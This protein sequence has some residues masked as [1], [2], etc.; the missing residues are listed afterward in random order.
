MIHTTSQAHSGLR[1]F[2]FSSILEGE[3]YDQYLRTPELNYT[4]PMELSFWYKRHTF[5]TETFRV[6][7]STNGSSWTWTNNITDADTFWKK[8][9]MTL[10]AGTKYVEIHYRS[11]YRWYLFID[12][13]SIHEPGTC[14]APIGLTANSITANSAALG[15]T[16]T[17]QASTWNIE[18]GPE[19]F[20]QGNGTLLQTA[21][22]PRTIT[23][24]LPGT[25]YSFYVQAVCQGNNSSWAGPLSF[26]TLCS[27]VSVFSE[28]FDAVISPSL[29]ICWG[30]AGTTGTVYTQ[31]VNAFSPPNCLYLYSGS[32]SNQ[33]VIAMPEVVNI[34]EGTHRLRFMARANISSGAIIEAGYLTNPSDPLS[35][36]MLQA[37]TLSLNYEEYIV[38]PGILGSGDKRLAFRASHSPAYSL[39]VDNVIWEE[40]SETPVFSV[41]PSIWNFG[42]INIGSQ[43]APKTFT[44]TNTGSGVLW[45]A[46]PALENPE[47][48]SLDYNAAHFPASLTANA[49]VTFDVIFSP[50]HSGPYNAR[51][52]VDF[53]NG[54]EGFAT[55]NLSGTGVERPEGS[56]CS[57]PIVI[58]Q[59]PLVNFQGNTELMGNDYSHKW[60]DPP[61]YFINGND[62]VFRFSLNEPGYLSGTMTSSESW[63]GL[64]IL[65]QCPNQ[66]QPAQVLVS[67]T[68]NGSSVSFFDLLLA[69]GEY[70]AIVSSYPPPQT[71]TFNLNLLIDPLPA[72]PQPTGLTATSITTT[73]AV[74]GWTANGN[75]NSWNVEY[76]LDGFEPGSGILLANVSNPYIL[77][78]LEPATAYAF[79]VQ[80]TGPGKLSNWA[81]PH[82]FSTL[83]NHFDIPFFENFDGVSTPEIP[84]C[85]SVINQNED[86]NQWQTVSFNASS[87]PNAMSINYNSAMDMDDWFFTPGLNLNAGVTYQ[88]KF[89][90]RAQASYY[91]EK[92]RVMWGLAPY[93]EEM[94]MGTIWDNPGISNTSYQE[95][96]GLFT[97]SVSGVYYLG[98][99]GYS[100]ADMWRLFVDDISVEVATA[101]FSL[102]LSVIIEGAFAP[103]NEVLMHTGINHLL[104]LSQPYGPELPYFGNNSPVWYYEGKESVAAMPSNVVDWVLIELRD[105]PEAE[106]A[107]IPLARKAALLL[108]T[109]QVVATNG[110]PL[111]FQQQI[112]QGLFVVIYHRN[113]LAIMSSEALTENNG[114]YTWDF[115]SSEARAFYNNERSPL[116]QGLKNL[117]NDAYAMFGGDADGNGQ[118]Q[119][120]DK[121]EVWNP[122]SGLSG[123][124]P[125]DF[126]MNGQVQVQD[127][128]DIWNQNS[129]IGSAVPSG[130]KK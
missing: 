19:G 79:Y 25:S 30:K 48:F 47:G 68:G 41:T 130:Q 52:S 20:E 112:S 126:D 64:F 84:V 90:Y 102:N 24:L 8:F 17:G 83:C 86:Q 38:E 10:P 124:L 23:G 6:G 35:F 92:L 62:M 60:I 18:W 7:T 22:N 97:P 74:L 107:N 81:G 49:S 67:A 43:S 123:Y 42:E 50:G 96:S 14:H 56:I 125:A 110:Q 57:N 44:I 93:P 4:V 128:N 98:W 59:L 29:P 78:G 121:N 66:Y 16:E 27:A 113:H 28:N 51:V 115:T 75:E 45:V 55:I 11:V 101:S 13:F 103:Q 114:V 88:V 46:A 109:G 77:D 32:A 34:N 63:I 95:G 116:K 72:Y 105:A 118:I 89:N 73:S 33:A 111:M 3:P 85:I 100:N 61:S 76:G 108:N 69:E 122:Q 5:G 94:T 2:R 127:K 70:F 39:L 26:A 129:G 37:K 87:P 36:V 15:W 104:P 65:E 117:G 91:P 1:S 82:A 120:Q 9:S 80:A 71:I 119:V 106:L 53:N 99:H 40:I 31:S 12:E 54:T 21:S 58:S